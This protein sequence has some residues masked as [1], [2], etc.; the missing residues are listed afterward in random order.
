MSSFKIM[1]IEDNIDDVDFIKEK[2][3]SILEDVEIVITYNGEEAL[4]VLVSEE[5][6]LP[7]LMLL[8]INMPKMNGIDFLKEIHNHEKKSLRMIP[9]IMMTSSS[10]TNDINNG[11]E[12]GANCF[13]VKPMG[14]K[15][16]DDMVDL[17]KDFWIN[18]VKFPK[19]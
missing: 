7:N 2:L 6:Q 12:N 17:I 5:G 15:E 19:V 11:Y 18:L 3:E 9:V 1:I 16:F 13:L 4:E 8:D 14:L 10:S